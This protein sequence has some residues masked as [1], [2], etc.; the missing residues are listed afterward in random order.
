VFV[1][2]IL[3]FSVLFS[4][5]DQIMRP[6]PLPRRG[7]ATVTR[8]PHS[9]RLFLELLET[10]VV[11][12]MITSLSQNSAPEGSASVLLT[13][14]GS[15]FLSNP[16]VLWNGMHVGTSFISSTQLQALIPA[17]D[18]T[19]EGT[20]S[21]SVAELVNGSFTQTSNTMSFTITEAP[22]SG[23]AGA[24]ISGVAGQAVSGTVAT[25]TD[26]GGPEAL[27]DY[28]A[29]IN[30]GDSSTSNGTISGPSGGVFSVSGSHTYAAA[31]TFT[32][33]VMIS[34]ET[35]TPVTVSEKAT[36]S[37]APA[38]PPLSATGGLFLFG[39]EGQ[40]LTAP[41]AT[42]SGGGATQ[43]GCTATIN[44]GDG[45]T[46]TGTITGPDSNGVFTVTGTH[47]YVEE[48]STQGTTPFTITVTI[49]C[50]TMKATVTDMA[51][52]SEVPTSGPGSNGLAISSLSPGTV[53]EGSASFTLTVNG[54]NFVNGATVQVNGMNLA[55]TLVNGQLQAT[56]PASLLSEE[57]GTE[58]NIA[59][60]SVTV[61]E[62][63]NGVTV[64]SNVANLAVT[65]APLS[66]TGGF[67]LSGAVGKSV[68]G[69]VATFTDAGGPEQL[70]DYS[71]TINW[72]DNSTSTGTI[73]S[74]DMNGVFTVSGSHTYATG[75]PFTI[76]VTISHETAAPVTVTSTANISGSALSATGGFFLFGSE[77]Q[78]LTATVATFS[79]GGATQ[80]GCTASI[81]WGDG[82]TS[83]GTISA[84]DTNGVFTVTGTHTYVEEFSTQGT[85]PFT[86]TVTI[87]CGTMK[88]TVTDT[89]DIA[90]AALSASGST[91]SAMQGRT[92]SGTVATFSD[93]GV[94]QSAA[95]PANYTATIDWGDGNSST[96]S[97]S[98]NVDGT[99]SV[100]GSNTY[101]R[102]A[103]Y[104]I[105]VVIGDQ[106][107]SAATVT[108]AAKVG[109]GDQPLAATGL[110]LTGT[111]SVIQDF[112]VAEFSD[113]DPT[114]HTGG[115]AVAINWG[116]GTPLDPGTVT[117]PGG[118]GT[119]FFVAYSH[120]YT[121][122]GTFTVEVQIFDEA[123]TSAT[124]FSTAT[125]NSAP[126]PLVP[127][128][129]RTGS[130]GKNLLL[131]TSGLQ[132]AG[133]Q[134][135]GETLTP[136]PASSVPVQMSA[137]VRSS[138]SGAA[139]DLYWELLGR[140]ERITDTNGLAADQLALTV[141]GSLG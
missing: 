90:E 36:I 10:R 103:T 47:T 100:S 79:G 30:W 101:K 59:P 136:S 124:T 68:S 73:S 60:I 127:G 102:A 22:I 107:G 41:L 55:T 133:Q 80:S 81:N 108:S 105:T 18:L 42:F 119:P 109:T 137:S 26:A 51:E 132:A 122:T 95:D 134:L 31:G 52:I 106:A 104:S 75:G 113:P 2:V 78:S 139:E 5:K 123:G 138:Q 27:S 32:V 65:E 120:T 38:P 99:F 82:S 13:V 37:A 46:S 12:S 135:S 93:P 50:G 57:T 62:T 21:V 66:G 87:T 40:S 4:A 6:N 8:R 76:S 28:S 34:H 74:P 72:G 128:G 7:S 129:G 116:D 11:P 45:T 111:V 15:G 88:A 110:D 9:R 25:F 91:I 84:P 126:A 44:W 63:I 61:V 77:G 33:S 141:E 19:D 35:A 71:A 3:L 89:A 85:S 23:T 96:G 112:T 54:L 140:G 29:T 53:P 39:S 69:T 125:V 70:S 48:F 94:A 64:T 20:A 131:G 115:Y 16:T 24:A 97:V 14:N 130:L 121:D 83:T 58:D 17:S 43:S 92:F 117:Q 98:Q 114:A 1:V 67:T 118:A 86:I 49:T 56:V